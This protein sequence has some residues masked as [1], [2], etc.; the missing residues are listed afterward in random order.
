LDEWLQKAIDVEEGGVHRAATVSSAK[1]FSVRSHMHSLADDLVEEEDHSSS[2][3]ST[4][5]QEASGKGEHDESLSAS[6][7]A[8]SEAKNLDN[9]ITTHGQDSLSAS[10][11]NKVL[12][13]KD[14]ESTVIKVGIHGDKVHDDIILVCTNA[15]KIDDR[16]TENKPPQGEVAPYPSA[17]HKLITS[18]SD[19]RQPKNEALNH[20][21]NVDDSMLREEMEIVILKEMYLEIG[22][23]NSQTKYKTDISVLVDD[24]SHPVQSNISTVNN[25]D[26]PTTPL[27]DDWDRIG[28]SNQRQRSFFFSFNS[29]FHKSSD[30][31]ARQTTSSR[32][33]T[34][35]SKEEEEISLTLV[36]KKDSYHKIYRIHNGAAI[37][38]QSWLATITAII[39][40]FHAALNRASAPAR[41]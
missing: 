5:G 17:S 32:S 33:Q 13:M 23:V 24:E 27:S 12:P 38:P 15:K 3:I 25:S 1:S 18:G 20:A 34:S 39:Q 29:F 26:P 35:P 22:S 4:D 28:P 10:E 19:I 9:T 21:V 6:R 2:I 8:L 40:S 14:E 30:S 16:S 41:D 7:N 36:E 37:L 11:E 31:V